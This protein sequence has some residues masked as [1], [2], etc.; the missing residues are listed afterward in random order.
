MKTQTGF[1]PGKVAKIKKFPGLVFLIVDDVLIANFHK[2]VRGKVSTPMQH[3]I[4]VF[5]IKPGRAFQIKSVVVVR[6]LHGK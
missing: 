2:A 4:I 3:K 1:I 6:V 5:A